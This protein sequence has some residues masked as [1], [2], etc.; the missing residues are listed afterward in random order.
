LESLRARPVVTSQGSAIP[1]GELA[2]VHVTD[3]P[4]AIRSENAELTGLVNI[5]LA[6]GN[7]DAFV[8]KASREIEAS[9][10]VPTG[11]RLQWTGEYEH[12]QRAYGR[13]ALVVPLVLAVIVGLLYLTSYRTTDLL[14]ILASVPVAVLSG[15]WLL[16]FLDYRLSIA[17][18]VGFVG[19]AGVAVETGMVMLLFLNGAWQRRRTELGA[20][21]EAD[22][23][24][25]I[26]EG[27]FLRLRPKLMT[28][29][30]IIAALL[31]I[32]IGSG[33][34]SDMMQRIA[35]PMVGG[36][37]GATLFTLLVIPAGFYLM[38]RNRLNAGAL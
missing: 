38:R 6:T 32:M 11:Y 9:G 26:I 17:V 28:A 22:L 34:G 31:P 24:S 1:L 3:G 29:T 21:V 15:M 16:W 36:M 27:A 23:K 30:V 8:T 13:L 2:R 25:A 37:V 4:A 5:V 33:T 18:V 20:P 19:L 7:L 14:L 12:M 35:A 10:I